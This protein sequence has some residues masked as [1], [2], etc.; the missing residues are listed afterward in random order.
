M[1]AL[2]S[3]NCPC[4][5]K[6]ARQGAKLTWNPGAEPWCSCT[7][8]LQEAASVYQERLGDPQAVT[9]ATTLPTS[10]GCADVTI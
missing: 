5:G 4:A 1:S 9:S 6:G 7:A 2:H 3:Y 10:P 8:E